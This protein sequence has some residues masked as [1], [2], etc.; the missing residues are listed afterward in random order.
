M[1]PFVAQYLFVI[2]SLTMIVVGLAVF[3]SAGRSDRS[4]REEGV[5][6]LVSVGVALAVYLILWSCSGGQSVF[7]TPPG[8][9][10]GGLVMY[11]T[12]LAALSWL[13]AGVVVVKRLVTAPNGG[14]V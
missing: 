10:P 11:M 8:G 2:Y 4:P 12:A 6:Y 14:T 3:M 7:S 13:V 5:D 9:I 1:A